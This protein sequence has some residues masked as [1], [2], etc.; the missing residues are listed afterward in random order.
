M[1]L[2]NGEASFFRWLD[3]SASDRETYLFDYPAE[4]SYAWRNGRS[5]KNGGYMLLGLDHAGQKLPSASAAFLDELAQR[6][7]FNQLV[8]RFPLSSARNG[9]DES[10]F[11]SQ[12]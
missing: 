1:L 12:R 10:S 9:G 4:T 11:S 7:R 5:E 6:H 3:P 8:R 2:R